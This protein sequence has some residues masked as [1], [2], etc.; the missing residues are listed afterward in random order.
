MSEI[1]KKIKLCML[2]SLF[3]LN[4]GSWAGEQSDES[5][6]DIDKATVLLR[7]QQFISEQLQMLNVP[8]DCFTKSGPHTN[9][10]LYKKHSYQIRSTVTDLLQFL[11]NNQDVSDYTHFIT[12]QAPIQL[13]MLIC[14]QW[15]HIALPLFGRLHDLCQTRSKQKKDS[16]KKITQG[17]MHEFWVDI[18][19]QNCADAYELQLIRLLAVNYKVYD[20]VARLVDD[21]ISHCK[22]REDIACF[23]LLIFGELAQQFEIQEGYYSDV[24]FDAIMLYSKAIK[25]GSTAAEKRLEY[26]EPKYKTIHR[27]LKDHLE[28]KF[29]HKKESRVRPKQTRFSRYST[30]STLSLSEAERANPTYIYKESKQRL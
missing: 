24:S 25:L 19:K 30:S 18:G 5:L 9:L 17:I 29:T 21:M 7:R 2:T 20:E 28:F 15:E 10:F 23:Y 3:V 11:S 12:L 1:L 16:I 4:F 6:L 26:I 27:S 13:C 22:F 14:Q 8:F